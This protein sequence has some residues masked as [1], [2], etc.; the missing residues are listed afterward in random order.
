MSIEEIKN[1][2]PVSDCLATA[3]QPSEAQLA[4][5][6]AAGF[7]VVVNLG[8]MDKRYCLDDEAGLVELLGMRYYHIPVEFSLPRA[9]DLGRFFDVMDMHRDSRVLVHCAANYRVSC[10]VAIYGVVRLGWPLDAAHDLVHR[11]WQPDENW[12]RFMEQSLAIAALPAG[13]Q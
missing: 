2:V 9:S 1:F 7:D 10:F 5:V 3:G 13:V 8:M 11:T 6:A 4:D 12:T